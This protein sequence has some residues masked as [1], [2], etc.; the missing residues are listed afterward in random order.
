MNLYDFDPDKVCL[1]DGYNLVRKA[2]PKINLYDFEA[3]KKALAL[4][5]SEVDL[6]AWGNVGTSIAQ[7]WLEIS[8]K[9]KIKGTHPF[10][11]IESNYALGVLT[12]DGRVFGIVK[13]SNVVGTFTFDDERYVEF[14]DGVVVSLTP[15]LDR[16]FLKLYPEETR[17]DGLDYFDPLD[18]VV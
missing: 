17:V 7:F 11:K 8:F 9:K 16:R 14:A 18:V 1:L 3:C 13:K 6:N 4:I 5:L 15:S 12:P 2:F 10:A